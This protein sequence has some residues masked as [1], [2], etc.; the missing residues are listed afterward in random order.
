MN[1]APEIPLLYSGPPQPQLVLAHGAGAPMDSEFM[2]SLAVLLAERGIGV[3]RFE[4]PFMRRRREEGGKRPP[5]RQQVLLDHWRQVVQQIEAQRGA[6]PGQQPLYIGGKSLG[7]RMASMVADELAA[8]GL[9]CLG[10]P[11]HP[12]R[13]PDR[14]RVEHLADLATPT[15]IFQGTRDALGS[16]LEVRDYTLSA[17]IELVWLADG[18]HD[19]KPRVRSG[20]SQQQ[21]LATV[22]DHIAAFIQRT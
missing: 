13:K 17:A 4:F 5:D 19:L 18:D 6:G 15:R 8:A 12:P 11:F 1:A 21:H 22:A 14:L 16:E 2:E 10:Y 9:V 3:V 7:G 20:F